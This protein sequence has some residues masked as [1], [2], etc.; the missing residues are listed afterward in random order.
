MKRRIEIVQ[1]SSPIFNKPNGNLSKIL[2][3]LKLSFYF[4]LCLL[5]WL[6]GVTIY[7]IF[8]ELFGINHSIWDTSSLFILLSLAYLL[9]FPSLYLEL[10]L[11]KHYSK[12]NSKSS[13][14]V[15]NA[16]NKE[17]KSLIKHPSFNLRDH[18]VTM[19]FIYTFFG[20]ALLQLL[21]KTYFSTFWVLAKWP[22]LLFLGFI[23]YSFKTVS[24]KLT[25][26][27]SKAE[28]LLN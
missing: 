14:I 26:N 20:C 19:F 23:F 21:F 2:I 13:L 3:K 27:I 8:S 24:D 5:I 18:N 12:I 1:N 10:K 6:V 28:S 15:S 25:V 4:S 22:L 17:L 11:L 16:L 7:S 9:D